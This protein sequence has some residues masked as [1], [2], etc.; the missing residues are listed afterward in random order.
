M[1]KKQLRKIKNIINYDPESLEHK[2]LIRRLKKQYAE[3]PSGK[4]VNLIEDLK[5]L[6]NKE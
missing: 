4:K 2:R 5:K 6:F 1:N 3:L